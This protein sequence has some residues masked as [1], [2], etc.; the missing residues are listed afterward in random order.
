MDEVYRTGHPIRL[1]EQVVPLDRD[2]DGTL[3]EYLFDISYQPLRDASGNVYAITSLSLDVTEQVYAR[4]SSDAAT[5]AITRAQRQLERVFSQAPVA[6]AVLEGPDH[7]FTLANPH[8]QALVGRTDLVGRTAHEAF[9]EL[10]AGGGFERLTR[11]FTTGQP[12]V[13]TELPVSLRRGGGDPTEAFFNV[14]YHP[15]L[16]EEETVYAIVVLGVD[17]TEQVRARGVTETLLKDSERS[18]AAVEEA[19]AQLEEQQMELELTNQ[20][21]QDNAAELEA[22][23]EELEAQAEELAEQ[24]RIAEAANRAKSDFLT[25]MSH[26]LRTPLNAIAGY[27]DL[28]LLGVRGTL[29]DPQREDVERMRRSGQH[30]LGLINDILNF[31]KLNAGQVEFQIRSTPLAALLDQLQDLVGPQLAAKSLRFTME[32]CDSTAAVEAD[33]DKVRQ[34]LLNLVTNAVKFTEATGAIAIACEIDDQRALI[35]VRDTGRGIPPEQLERVFDPFVQVDRHLTPAS[36]QGVG[37]G[38]AISRDLANGMGGQLSA[39]SVPGEGSTFTLTL[40]RT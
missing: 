30:L 1:T 35:H 22:Q 27:A 20:Q 37:L 39:T 38:L 34:I 24:T 11:V 40:R 25:T 36:Q 4:R 21:L 19:N 28:L 2:G 26:E 9:P 18:R 8:Y 23:A 14:A 32:N 17:V 31:T 29:T 10:A 6:I 33:P 12:L 7:C 15:L 13:A 5:R 3:E 16:D